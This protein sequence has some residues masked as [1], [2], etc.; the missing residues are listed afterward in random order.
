MLSV[1]VDAPCTL[2]VKAGGS[3]N[4][5]YVWHRDTT[6]IDSETADTLLLE[7]VSLADEAEY[8]MG[9]GDDTL[10]AQWTINRYLVRFDARGGSTVDS[11]YVDYNDTVNT[12][13]APTKTDCD[14]A[15][16]YTGIVGSG[17]VFTGSEPITGDITV[18]AL[19]TITDGENNVYTTVS[20]GSQ[21]WMAENLKSTKYRDGTEISRVTENAEWA[22]LS[23]PGYCW[24]DNDSATYHGDYGILYN[25]YTVADTNS[26]ELAPAGWHVPTDD[27]WT[28]LVQYCIA[29]GYNWDGTTTGNKIGKSLAAITGW[30]ASNFQGCVG[31]DTLSNNRT[32]FSALPGGCRDYNGTFYY[33]GSG[34]AN[35]F[36]WSATEVLCRHLNFNGP[37]LFR[38]TDFKERGYSVRCVR[39]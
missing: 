12:P 26:H 14:F 18:Y 9:A 1:D 19:W 33:I 10:Y 25:W 11:Q 8:S 7:N 39:D 37:N 23:S 38:L 13:A 17:T 34:N 31:N 3:G 36:W 32:G 15:G 20:I 21:V 22:A 6:I 28:E 24:Y 16:W 27:E 29:G 2:W 4:L 30:T 5:D 35:G